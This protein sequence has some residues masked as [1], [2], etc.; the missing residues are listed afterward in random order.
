MPNGKILLA[1]PKG[2]GSKVCEIYD[3]ATQSFS[4][5]GAFSR[6]ISSD[7]M[8][9]SDGRVAAMMQNDLLGIGGPGTKILEIYDPATD[10]L[11]PGCASH[12]LENPLGARSGC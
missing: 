3:P 1:G 4:Q 6:S 2:Q 12:Y 10:T 11:E 5:G 9:M 8:P 7:L